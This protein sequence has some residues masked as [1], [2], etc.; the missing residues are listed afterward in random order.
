MFK[1]FLKYGLFLVAALGF[2][3]CRQNMQNSDKLVAEVGNKKL[4][5]SELSAVIPNELDKTDSTVMAE[6][7]IRKWIREELMLLKAE[8]N[9]SFDL[10]DVT[11]ELEEYRNSL[12]IFRYKNELLAQRMDT[13]VSD[14]E[15]MEYYL[16][17]AENFKLNR[18]IVKAAY[19]RIPAELANPDLLKEMSS[20]STEEGINELRYY[21][22]QYA[23]GFDIFTDRWV[24]LDRVMNNIPTT[25]ENPEQ[26][27]KKNQFLE[28]NDSSYYYL[29]TIHDYLLRNEQA[30]EDYVR[31]DIKSLILNRRKIEFL[32]DLENNIFQEGINRNSFKIYNIET[33]EM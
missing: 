20:N 14:N 28:Y 1:L 8:E 27:L 16:E 15:I 7:Y 10:K 13:T 24:E 31:N 5:L 21:C 3:G 6:E 2:G 32:K 26:F 25:I 33:N 19:I 4:Y 18:D 30:P 12:I 29:V 17:H 23:K 11:R 22:L 9:L